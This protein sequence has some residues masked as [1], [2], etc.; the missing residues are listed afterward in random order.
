MKS[1][2][3]FLPLFGLL[4]FS[5]ALPCRAFAEG[6]AATVTSTP[7]PVAALFNYAT[8]YLTAD[9]LRPR[10]YAT[11]P[12]DNLV[13]VIDT[14]SLSVIKTIPIG[15][16]PQG[17]AVSADGSKLWVANSGSTTFGIGIVDLNTLT[18]LPSY[19]TPLLP[20]DI[21]EGAGH[22]LYLTPKN[23]SFG[24]N[25]GGMMQIDGDTGTF[26]KYFGGF[27]VY[28][29]AVI[30]VSPDRNTLFFGNRGLSPSTL[31]R[32]DISTATPALLQSTGNVGSNGEAIRVSHN[33]QFLVYP[34]GSG[35]S[36]Y[37][38]YEIPTSNLS[39]IN[40][41]F[42]VGA[43]P[44]S[45][46]FSN[47][48]SLLYHGTSSQSAVKIFDTKTFVLVGTIPLGSS[49]NSSGGYDSKDLVVDRSGRWLFVA[50]SFFTNSGF[51]GD[52]RVFDVGPPELGN[53]STRLNV[54]QDDNVL[55]G[56]LIITGNQ[57]KKVAIRAI[58][59]SL[60]QAGISGALADPTL[61]L[62]DSST[63]IIATNDDWQTTQV[64]GV[65]TSS[66][67]SEIQ[68]RGIAP[69]QA[70][71]S[72]IIA[73]LAPGNYTAILRGKNNTTGIA[74]VE[75]YDLDR[76]ANSK[77]G[78]ISTRGFVQTGANVMIGGTIVTGNASANLLVRAIGPSL[79]SAGVPNPLADPMLELRDASGTLE[80]SNDDWRTT[81][82]TAI[83][84]TGLAPTNNLESAILAT[85]VPGPHTAIV[86]GKNNGTG[87]A[88]VEIYQLAN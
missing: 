61:E 86:R 73:V 43:Y 35:N 63:A 10:V 32:Y 12:N 37:N 84:N 27:D 56:G 11:V 14:A 59:P 22:R 3:R 88:L 24:P 16:S 21:K 2:R 17:L 9:P 33:G 41:S 39:G 44:I 53:I 62:H 58:G 26:Q 49:P 83:Q 74:V 1:H 40:G 36:G 72:V 77:L 6:D 29:G 57:S 66:Q 13:I 70:A 60:S 30:D 75:T 85:V 65:I 71:E 4:L 34:N 28:A 64:G 20:F 69:G 23:Q 87:V 67:V 50:T 52:L 79:A 81:Q 18:T 47:D 38:T 45:A 7:A 15:S 25:G 48:D 80:S 51:G 42:N 46:A 55:I 76:T 54:G 68:S 31:A 78:N 5:V 82:E 19:S 8:G